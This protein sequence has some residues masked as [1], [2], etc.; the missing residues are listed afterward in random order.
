MHTLRAVYNLDELK[1]HVR[2]EL[3][4]QGPRCN[5]NHLDVSGLTDFTGLFAQ[6]NFNGDVSQWNMAN[7]RSTRSMFAYCSFSGDVSMWKMPALNDASYMFMHCPFSGDLSSWS[8]PKDCVAQGLVDRHFAGALPRPA[9]NNE[10]DYH[11]MLGARGLPAYFTEYANRVGL[12]PT[13]AACMLVAERIPAWA[14]DDD[15]AWVKS[16]E[17]F[18]KSLGLTGEHL[19]HQLLHNTRLENNQT[20]AMAVQELSSAP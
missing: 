4:Q 12:N 15:Y 19:L 8:F 3:G 13:T 7:A 1:A 20:C 9:S 18:G 14:K 10:V 17:A 6:T 5:L 16:Q 2:H 11:A